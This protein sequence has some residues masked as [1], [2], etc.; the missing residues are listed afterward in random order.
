MRSVAGDNTHDCVRGTL[1]DHAVRGTT[2]DCRVLTMR[3]RDVLFSLTSG[4][5]DRQIAVRLGVSPRTVHKHLEHVYRKLGVVTRTAAVM[6]VVDQLID[7]RPVRQA[8]SR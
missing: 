6:R 2:P 7:G 4:E 1:M 5:T 3:E 8:P